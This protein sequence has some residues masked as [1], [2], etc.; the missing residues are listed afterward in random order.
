MAGPSL[1]DGTG[2]AVSILWAAISQG[3]VRCGNGMKK[4]PVA[5]L[6]G[7]DEEIT[8]V[9]D[10]IAHLLDEHLS[11]RRRTGSPRR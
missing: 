6:G 11:T 5:G 3:A 4:A 7:I 8:D 2:Q 1:L 9:L 10:W